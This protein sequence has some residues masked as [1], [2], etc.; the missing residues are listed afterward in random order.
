MFLNVD[1]TTLVGI[2]R[3]IGMGFADNHKADLTITPFL[4]SMEYLFTI[5]SKGQIF[6]LFQHPIERAISMLNYMKYAKDEPEYLESFKTMTIKEYANS[7]YCKNNY[8]TRILSNTMRGALN[9]DHYEI[10]AY[11]LRKKI[12]VGLTDR[13][14]ESI[15]RFE[16]Y[17]GWRYTFLPNE[18]EKCRDEYLHQTHNATEEERPLVKVPQVGAEEYE[19]L[20]WQNQFDFKLYNVAVELFHNNEPRECD[21]SNNNN[22]ALNSNSN[23]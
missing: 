10:A 13:L 7:V 22:S 16:Q 4:Y 5:K 17:F 23:K 9:D 18:Q 1:I 21:A 6:T 11:N 2:N 14:N 19:L 3:A 15:D 8:Y 20:S 12:I